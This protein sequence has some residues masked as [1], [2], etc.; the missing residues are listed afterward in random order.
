[1]EPRDILSKVDLFSDAL[2]AEQ[3]GFLAGQSRPAFFRAETRLMTQGSLGGSM[4]VI[5]RGVVGVTFVDEHGREQAVASLGPG[6]VVGEMSLFTGD[7]RT[8][9]VS[10]ITNVDA[11][12]ITKW[13]LERVFAKAPDLIDRFADV[14]A[15]RQAELSALSGSAPTGGR[16]LRQPGAQGVCQPVRRVMRC[17]FRRARS[18]RA[19]LPLPARLQ[20]HS[21]PAQIRTALMPT[22][23]SVLDLIGN[24]PLLRLRRAS[25]AT[26]C[27][28]LGKAEFLNPGQSVKDR[29]ALWIVRAAERAGTLKPGGTIVEGTAGN[30]GIGLALVAKALGYRCVIVI[31]E[32]QSEEK[33]LALR[34]GGATLIEVPAAPYRNPNNYVKVSGRLAEQL[35]KTEKGGAI[36]ANQF[37]NVAN[38]QAHIEFDRPGDMGSDRRQD[39]CLRFGGRHRRDACRGRHLPQGQDPRDQDRAG[40][41]ARRGA[42]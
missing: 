5:M 30:T 35:A 34:I 22:T 42:L 15:K 32:T 6:E 19:S 1:M 25:E 38:R 20:R 26:G 9:T 14:L 12:E 4:Y 13:S 33:K 24:T 28:I 41:R 37:D 10:A 11:I 31:P 29:A 39:R 21:L 36:W 27:D 23:Q 2:D 8:A 18:A 3:I 7:R 17:W 40:R 16:S